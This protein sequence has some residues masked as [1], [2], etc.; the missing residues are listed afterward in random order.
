MKS[1]FSLFKRPDRGSDHY[2]FRFHFRGKSYT[3]CLETA[4]AKDAQARAKLKYAEIT[5]AVRQGEFDRIDNTKTRHEAAGKLADLIAAY[6]VSPSDANA[7]TRKINWRA[8][9]HIVPENGTILD[10]TPSA[11]RAHFTNVN[12][13][14]LAEPDQLRAASLRRTG[15]A[16]WRKAKSLF[17]PKCLEFYKGKDL[18]HPIMN[19]FVAAGQAA[20]FSG[21]SVPK[22]AY[23][24]PREEIIQQTLA[25]WAELADT[26][27]NLYLAVGHERSFGLRIS[28]VAQVTWGWHTVRNGYPALDNAAHVKGGTGWVQVRALDPYFTQMQIQIDLHGWHGEPDEHVITGEDTYRKKGLFR[29]ATKWLRGLGWA[30]QKTNHAL[31]ALVGGQVAMRYGIYEAQVFLRHSSVKVTEQSY[32]HFVQKFKPASTEELPAKWATISD[33][34]RTGAVATLVASRGLQPSPA[35]SAPVTANETVSRN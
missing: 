12:A 20:R 4:D 14:A 28:E 33:V 6:K 21:H 19:E 17:V 24:P 7:H 26:D 16:I 29:A 5:D 32:S 13:A 10:L 2:Y 11:A 23:N 22:V 18:Y 8:L 27:R 9:L 34:T 25:A 30:T 3:R 35:E 31:R 1:K 15:N